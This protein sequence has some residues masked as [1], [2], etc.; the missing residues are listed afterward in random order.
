MSTPNS[1]L[2]SPTARLDVWSLLRL[3]LVAGG[4]ALATRSGQDISSG[5]IETV[6]G[7][8]VA[9]LSV[10]WSIYVHWNAKLV[11]AEVAARPDVPVVSSASG[12]IKDGP[13]I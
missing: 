6:A 12:K 13:G 11:P 3:A 5:D 2:N 9:I 7:A 8:L 10:A 1:D 4:T